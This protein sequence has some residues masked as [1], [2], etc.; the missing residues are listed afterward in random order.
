M[1]DIKYNWDLETYSATCTITHNG[2]EFVGK[3][4]CH[5][6]DRDLA[7]T[8]TGE[9]IAEAR[10]TLLVLRHIRDNELKP[11]LKSLKQLYYSI[12]HSKKYNPKSYESYML[13]RQIRLLEDEL[14][15][16]KEEI[17]YIKQELRDY[18]DLKEKGHQMIREHRARKELA[19]NNE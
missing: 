13:Y 9:I 5:P 4:N 1:Y 10:A 14:A 17:K 19:E 11:Q 3:A 12:K 8:L 15:D 18:I 16:I 7:S 2:L 6:E